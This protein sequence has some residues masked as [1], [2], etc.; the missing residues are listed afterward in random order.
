MKSY[1]SI[2]LLV[3]LA[4]CGGFSPTPETE[5]EML[6]TETDA[7]TREALSI[8][9]HTSSPR[10]EP[11]KTLIYQLAFGIDYSQP[12]KYLA[13]GEQTRISDPNITDALR[14]EQMNYQPGDLA[15]LGRIYFWIKGEFETWRAGG[16]T[17]GVVTVDEL[18]ASRR[19][20]GC[21]DWGLVFAALA[22]ELGYP[23]VVVDSLSLAWAREFQ[24]G[25]SRGFTGHVFVEVF[26]DQ[27][28]V[29]VDAT[30]NWYVEQ[31]YDPAN[32]V[33][34]LKGGIS[35]AQ[36]EIYGFYVM[37]KGL[38]TWDYGIHSANQLNI[39][40]EETAHLLDLEN[41]VYPSYTFQRFK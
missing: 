38:D 30:N 34:P 2:F 24:M 28:W 29:L 25:N 41:L 3:L 5:V 13:Q 20:G 35:G 33:I 31:G 18:L 15:M 17:I 36:D 8:P 39:L 9:T 12:E 26:I 32:P 6:R 19:L 37:R 7:P 21:H 14:L 10:Q 4:A 23:A 40:M 16:T 22:R 11:T 27:H 1:W